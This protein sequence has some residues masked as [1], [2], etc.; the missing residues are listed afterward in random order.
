MKSICVYCG[1][2]NGR[3]ADYKIAAKDLGKEL[4]HQ[5]IRLVYGGANV[6]VMTA[7]ADS[8]LAAGGEVVGVIPQGLVKKEVAHQGLT[9]LIITDSMHQRKQTM[10]DLSD[11][12][13]ALPGGIGT[14]EE[15]FE[16][17]TWT[18]LGFHSKPC[19]LL[20]ISGF[21]DDLI[22][23]LDHATH[24]LFLKPE[25]RDLLLVSSSPTELIKKLFNVTLPTS[26]KWIDK[27]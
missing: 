12:F 23:F 3:L 9:E 22:R 5:N 7:I 20:N 10:A 19:G 26:E 25:H 17:L 27:P 15:L 18:Q 13:I 24:E 14:L 4:A 11:A 8:A 21:Y 1:S 2:S 6:G 16:A